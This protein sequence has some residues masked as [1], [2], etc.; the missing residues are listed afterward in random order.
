MVEHATGISNYFGIGS[1]GNSAHTWVI[2]VELALD[3][4]GLLFWS[5]NL[6][7]AVLAEDHHLSLMVVD[8]IL[9]QQLHNFP[10]YRWLQKHNTITGNF[11]SNTWWKGLP[12]PSCDEIGWVGSFPTLREPDNITI[13]DQSGASLCLSPVTFHTQWISYS[14]LTW[15]LGPL[16]LSD[17][18][19]ATINLGTL[20][21]GAW[22]VASPDGTFTC[23][24]TRN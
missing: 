5:E 23:K 13:D 22:K 20:T 11:T 6:V 10:A 18:I 24:R 7:E 8:L 9:A 16:S 4:L 17:W 12:G 14:V 3:G 21:K 2:K 19:C 15:H 1:S